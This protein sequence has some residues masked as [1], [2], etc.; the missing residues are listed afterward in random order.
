MSIPTV[1]LNSEKTFYVAAKHELQPQ[2]ITRETERPL[3][4]E[5]RCTSFGRYANINEPK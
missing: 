5:G 4:I 3:L 2:K 1:V